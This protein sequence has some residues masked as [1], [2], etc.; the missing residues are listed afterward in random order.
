MKDTIATRF[1]DPLAYEFVGMK[2]DTIRAKDIYSGLQKI[3]QDTSLNSQI[4]QREAVN[5]YN[6]KNNMDSILFYKISVT[7]K[8]KGRSGEF[9]T[10]TM[11]LNY[12]PYED[13]FRPIR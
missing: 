9:V 4:R 1:H 7:Y 3:V 12:N 11:H 8:G 2:V 6:F 13:K 5:L 10:D